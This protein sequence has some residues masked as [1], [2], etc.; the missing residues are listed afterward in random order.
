[1][2][3]GTS[4][5]IRSSTWRP[6]SPAA[7]RLALGVLGV[8]TVALAILWRWPAPVGI[9]LCLWVG[10]ALCHL[11]AAGYVGTAGIRLARVRAVE[12]E[13]DVVFARDLP[14]G[15]KIRALEDLLRRAPDGF[16]WGVH[17]HLRHLYSFT[18]A[19]K[20][21]EHSDAILARSVMDAYIV[22]IL[23]GWVGRKDPQAAAR[24]LIATADRRPDLRFVA[25]ACRLAAGDAQRA[26]GRPDGA[27]ECYR[28]VLAA[29]D[30]ALAPYH[31]L[32]RRRLEPRRRWPP[33]AP[34]SLPARTRPG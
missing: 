14:P 27:A 16:S 26:A 23:S 2:T 15:E 13:A 12:D 31:R 20:A 22:D 19:E 8:A 10:V 32:A 24:N 17:N 11:I 9:E 33:A 7:L 21:L 34:R 4:T 18:D 29:D 3:T 25:A 28:L 30:A 1:M 5:A 6:G